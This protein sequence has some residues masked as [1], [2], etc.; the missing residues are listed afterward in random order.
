MEQKKASD[1]PQEL[2]NLFEGYETENI[3][4]W[5][6]VMPMNCSAIADARGRKTVFQRRS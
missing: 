2:L 6:I 3:A 4:R 1:F 5:P